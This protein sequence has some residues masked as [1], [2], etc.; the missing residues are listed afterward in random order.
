MAESYIE[1]TGGIKENCKEL[2]SPSVWRFVKFSDYSIVACDIAYVTVTVFDENG[3][4]MYSNDNLI[5][6]DADEQEIIVIRVTSINKNTVEIRQY[7]LVNNLV[8]A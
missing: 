3:L 6:A 2:G 8:V 7:N 5:A 1:Y 4:F